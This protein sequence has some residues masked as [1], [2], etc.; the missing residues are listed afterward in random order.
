MLKKT[1]GFSFI[2]VMVSLVL[3]ALTV[4]TILPAVVLV[5]KERSA[6]REERLAEEYLLDV[7]NRIYYEGEAVASHHVSKNGTE[8][9]LTIRQEPVEGV[10]ITWRGRNARQYER[11]LTK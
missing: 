9:Q 4:G 11:C 8:Y 5:Q 1:A 6:I 3:F 10:C 7:Y 2:E